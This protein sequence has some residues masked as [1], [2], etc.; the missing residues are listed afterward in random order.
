V[1][2]LLVH[3]MLG[4]LP[5]NRVPLVLDYHGLAGRPTGALAAVAARNHV[6][7]PTV[8]TY[9]QRVRGPA[10][11]LPLPAELVREAT[12]PSL[13]GE[14][15]TARKRIAAT[16]HLAAPAPPSSSLT[17]AR[18]SDSDARAAAVTAGRVLAAAG[19]LPVDVMLAAVARS[20][21]FRRDPLAFTQAEVVSCRPIV[22]AIGLRLDPVGSQ[23]GMPP[24]RG[25]LKRRSLGQRND[26]S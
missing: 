3:Q 15:H 20:R 11:G 7:P 26:R 8:L 4:P 5:R 23:C 24:R 16:L 21:R 6:T 22:W 10:T 9:V 25:T 17:R 12:P 13:P 18:V 1:V 19:P 2:S 14:D